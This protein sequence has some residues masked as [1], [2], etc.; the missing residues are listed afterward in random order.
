[1]AKKVT[2]AAE[3][4]SSSTRYHEFVVELKQI[5]PPI[6]IDSFKEWIR[7]GE[8]TADQWAKKWYGM[9]FE[10]H[11]KKGKDPVYDGAITFLIYHTDL[12]IPNGKSP[13]EVMK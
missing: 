6:A 5:R 8:L 7:E 11:L 2:M 12:K 9:S 4:K 3:E 10:N 13:E 1:M